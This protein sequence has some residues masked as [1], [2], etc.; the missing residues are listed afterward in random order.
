[1]DVFWILM[2]IKKKFNAKLKIVNKKFTGK[3]PKKIILPNV[4]T[5]RYEGLFDLDG[6]YAAIVD[7]CKNYG[8]RWHEK[9]YKHKV[10]SPKGA[11]QEFIW[12]MDKDVTDFVSYNVTIDAHI[13]D[14]LEVQV[15]VGG[16]QKILSNARI[17]ITI[18]GTVN[19]DWQKKF[20]GSEVKEFAY[21]LYTNV[22]RRELEVTY[23]DQLWYRMYNLQAIMK[24]YFDMQ[25]KHHAYKGYLGDN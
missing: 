23:I 4:I 11:E 9:S 19:F 21:N 18:K 7:W 17:E 24:K 25:S 12:T 8:Y 13:W 10:P 15:D 20:K 14:M 2:D 22:M 1:L 16:K 3:L 6:L 5:L